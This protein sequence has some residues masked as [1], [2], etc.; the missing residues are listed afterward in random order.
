MAPIALRLM[1]AKQVMLLCTSLYLPFVAA[2]FWPRMY[3]LVPTAVLLGLG[4]GALWTS[5]AVYTVTLALQHGRLA[6][7][8]SHRAIQRFIA[9]FYCFYNA[10]QVLGNLLT[11][12]V[13]HST[14]HAATQSVT[15][16]TS[17]S[18][19]TGEPPPADSVRDI[20]VLVGPDHMP[21]WHT[22]LLTQLDTYNAQ[23]SA[24]DSN[25]TTLLREGRCLVEEVSVATGALERL[26][27]PLVQALCVVLSLILLAALPSVGLSLSRGGRDSSRSLRHLAT[28]LWHLVTDPRLLLLAPL[29]IF[30]GLESGFLMADFTQ[31]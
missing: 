23:K 22:Y 19:A 21:S 25:R 13:L 15:S 2:Q 14:S 24:V 3:V 12:T 29:V 28:G 4:T 5:Q 20:T 31:V 11:L 16:L 6:K 26:L 18:A 17:S 30:T 8:C 27:L 7:L 1:N 9:F 10:S